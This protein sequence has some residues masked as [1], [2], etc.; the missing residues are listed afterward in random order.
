MLYALGILLLVF[1]F[2]LAGVLDPHLKKLLR[3]QTLNYDAPLRVKVLTKDGKVR[4]LNIPL[5]RL[6]EVAAV[7]SYVE[8]PR[9]LFPLNDV[10]AAESYTAFG[11]GSITV[12]TTGSFSGYIVQG[13][14]N[15]PSN[16]QK[17]YTQ[18]PDYFT[19]SGATT[20]SST[21]SFA[22]VLNG[23]RRSEI[24][25]STVYRVGTGALE[26]GKTGEGVIIGVIDTGINFCHPAF[27]D[28]NGNT[29]VKLFGFSSSEAACDGIYDPELGV[30]QY[31][32]AKI[33]T[34]IQQGYCNLD[35]WG[36]G[37]HVT[38]T[39]VGYWEGSLYNGIAPGATLIVYKLTRMEDEEAITGLRWIKKK[40]QELGLPAVVNFSLG[41]HYGPHDGNALLSKVVD[42]VSGPGFIVITAAGNS[43]NVP[44]H[45]YSIL[46]YDTVRLKV[47]TSVD[48]EGWYTGGSE[49]RVS[50]C[51]STGCLTAEPG[52]VADGY[53]SGCQVY[54]DNT[55][56]SHP[57]NG[58][59]YFLISVS[60]GISTEFEI[61]LTAL[62]GDSLRVDMWIANYYS[63]EG[64]FLSNYE[65]DE[66]GGYKFTL[67]VPATANEIIAVGAIGSKPLGDETAVNY[68]G[69]VAPFSSRGPTRD[70]RVRP[71]VV[72]PGYFVCSAN[73]GFTQGSD[74]FLCGEGEYYVAYAGTSM[75]S[76][77]VAGL[78]AL[79][80]QDNP[81]ASPDEVKGWLTANAVKDVNTQYPSLAYGYGKAIYSANTNF[82]VFSEST[83]PITSGSFYNLVSGGGGGG[84]GG[85]NTLN[86]SLLSLIGFF[87][88]RHLLLSLWKRLR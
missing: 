35:L 87:L 67:S 60:C 6:Q 64:Y 63:G 79:Y 19:C 59:G 11:S 12:S 61:R 8:A 10:A 57:L 25:A 9:K 41:T 80:L 15:L 1:N 34:L 3:L 65:K 47:N 30:C 24:G 69:R 75:A 33:N 45:A 58:D 71:H 37:T 43:G 32:E 84:G 44:V 5:S 20:F 78:V 81:Q 52:G 68:L 76:P 77:V 56:L 53:L 7:Y 17:P 46:P 26:S 39:A 54:V 40:A 50:L 73:S 28:E 49:Y 82:A 18:L 74:K 85:C 42:E 36:H 51:S 4:T 83:V 62:K 72:A 48:V 88:I 16:C 23:V 70:G 29:K 55:I 21:G 66:T 31:D 86:T 2:S 14:V 27:L 38:G 13:S 22:L